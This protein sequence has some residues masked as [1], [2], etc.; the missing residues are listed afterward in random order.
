MEGLAVGLELAIACSI[1]S[2]I[3]FMRTA[4]AR[5]DRGRVG[6]PWL[7]PGAGCLPGGGWVVSL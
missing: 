4:Q 1:D 7:V 6:S 3:S 2:G 5:V